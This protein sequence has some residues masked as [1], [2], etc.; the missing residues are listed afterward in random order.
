MEKRIRRISFEPPIVRDA[1]ESVI[2]EIKQKVAGPLALTDRH[3][4]G[5][6]I[7]ERISP[8]DL[9]EF[10]PI[11]S[12]IAVAAPAAIPALVVCAAKSI[13]R[14]AD[15]PDDS[16]IIRVELFEYERVESKEEQN[17]AGTLLCPRLRR[18]WLCLPTVIELDE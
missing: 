4:I 14:A 15:K 3:P 11:R 16:T 10:T 18:V 12:K 2:T 13:T 7:P 8:N 1:F 6:L 9:I 17:I 5:W